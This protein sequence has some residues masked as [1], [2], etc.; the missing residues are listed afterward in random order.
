[1][2]DTSHGDDKRIDGIILRLVGKQ[3]FDY[4]QCDMRVLLLCVAVRNR[5]NIVYFFVQFFLLLFS[6]SHNRLSEGVK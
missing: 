1:M 4:V 6:G 3:S 2:H 5:V